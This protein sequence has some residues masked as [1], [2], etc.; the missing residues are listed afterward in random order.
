MRETQEGQDK[1]AFC[2]FQNKYEYVVKDFY[3]HNY[4]PS[5]YASSSTHRSTSTTTTSTH[6]VSSS[7][8]CVVFDVFREPQEERLVKIIVAKNDGDEKNGLV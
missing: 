4:I 7:L 5:A 2:F 3:H 8:L 1:R 6:N